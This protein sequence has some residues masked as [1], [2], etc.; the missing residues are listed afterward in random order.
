ML[1]SS[2]PLVQERCINQAAEHGRRQL[3]SDQLQVLVEILG[4]C[5]VWYKTVPEETGT[6]AFARDG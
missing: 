4:N 2:A 5:L 6:A 3:R 1:S